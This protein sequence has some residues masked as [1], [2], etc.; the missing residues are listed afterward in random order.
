MR[1]KEKRFFERGRLTETYD[2]LKFFL[3]LTCLQ[4]LCLT[5]TYDVL[6]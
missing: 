2:V 6:K 4:V 5:E 3:P 1:E